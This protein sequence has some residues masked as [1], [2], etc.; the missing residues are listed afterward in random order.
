MLNLRV[1]IPRFLSAGEIVS[2]P[3]SL[4]ALRA[5]DAVKVLVL[6]SNSLLRSPGIEA[7]LGRSIR[8]E[9]L[10]IVPMP[11]GEPRL[12]RLEPVLAEVDSFAPDWLV[13]VGGGSTLDGAKLAWV[14]HEHPDAALDRLARPFAL[15]RLR[16]R[17]RFVAVPTTSGTGSEVSSAAVFLDEVSGAKRPI[18]SHELLPDLAV[19]DPKL[20]VGV[21]STVVA[22]A[23]FDA[24]SHAIEG[25]VSRLDNP[26]VDLMAEAAAEVLLRRLA[27]TQRDPA[28]LRLR[29][30]VMGAATMAGWVQNLKLPGIGHAI[31]HQLGRFGV[32]HG[33][34]TGR[35]LPGAMRF[36]QADP[37][38]AARY[39]RLARRCGLRDGSE[40]VQAVEALSAEIRLGPLRVSRSQIESNLPSLAAAV[41][42][43]PCAR[44]NPRPVT[45]A[46]VATLLLTLADAATVSG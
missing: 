18:V 20:T 6:A 42:E 3:G 31:A 44:A 14:L 41:I 39:D 46:E 38:V 26:L 16:G 7:E 2:G 33:R 25:Y 8:A 32:P 1:S 12:G 40:L 35:L 11:S 43:D 19:L 29:L 4:G 5:L 21:P 10:R 9:G 30:E 13:A 27:Q 15:P 37:A 22:D 17:T 36:N 45:A 24:L 34:A 28:D 23:G